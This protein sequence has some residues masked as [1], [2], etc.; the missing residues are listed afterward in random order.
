M[1]WL[2]L[3]GQPGGATA[4]CPFAAAD[5]LKPATRHPRG[6]DVMSRFGKNRKA[7]W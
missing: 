3:S 7:A 5:L 6:H 1:L 2:C 4:G